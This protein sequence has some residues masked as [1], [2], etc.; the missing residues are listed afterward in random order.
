MFSKAKIS[1]IIAIIKYYFL[2]I[3]YLQNYEEN[4]IKSIGQEL[5]FEQILEKI[6]RLEDCNQAADNSDSR[7][8]TKIKMTSKQ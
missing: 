6:L 1:N 3:C 2:L 8:V 4:P 7:K 5:P